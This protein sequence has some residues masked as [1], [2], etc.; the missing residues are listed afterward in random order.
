VALLDLSGLA[1]EIL[2]LI[3]MHV[4]QPHKPTL[5]SIALVNKFFYTIICPIL[6]STVRIHIEDQD[7]LAEIV[8]LPSTRIAKHVRHLILGPN[9]FNEQDSYVDAELPSQAR[10]S[11]Y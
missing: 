4:D 9:L 3:F 1:N 6:F 7:Q 5:Q 2:H 10:D 8:Q 11:S